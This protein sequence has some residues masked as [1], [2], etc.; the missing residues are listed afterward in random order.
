MTKIYLSLPLLFFAVQSSY[1]Q[2]EKLINGIVLHEKFP[3]GKVEVANF[4]SKKTTLTNA[5]GEFSILVKAGDELF[6]ISKSHDIKKILVNQN[7]INKNLII[8]LTLKPEELKEV[9]ITKIPSI[10]LSTD[11]KYEQGKLDEL[12]LEKAVRTP[13]ILGINNG[14]IENGMDLMRIGGIITGLFAKEKEKLKKTIPEVDFT[15]L[16]KSSCD[17]KF[18]LEN[19]KLKP[20]E[21]DLFLQFCTAD[22]KSKLLLEHHNILSMM[23]FLSAKN[24]EFKKL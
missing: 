6:F 5:S 2:T 18:Y 9:V 13:K 3:V 4:S 19:L 17:Q 22:S 10:Q 20:D 23:D 15:A 7:T 1:S 24:I 11:K 21:I 14:T 12:A 16:A 8:S